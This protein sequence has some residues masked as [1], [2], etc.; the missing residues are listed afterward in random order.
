MRVVAAAT[1]LCLLAGGALA[2]PLPSPNLENRI[3]APLPPPPQPPVINGPL[4][5]GR[6]TT[7]PPAR[8][9]TFPDK[10]GRCLD[11]AAIAARDLGERDAYTRMCANSR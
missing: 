4:G 8:L 7:P 10:V 3:P 9:N 1:M 5:Q 6:G 11:E 2:Q